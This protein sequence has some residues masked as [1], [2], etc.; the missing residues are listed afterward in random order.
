MDQ[1]LLFVLFAAT[2]ILGWWGHRTAALILF[3]LSLALSA[4]DYL[5]H[6]T[7]A[8]PLPF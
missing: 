6:A 2:M 3:F 4:A 5:H 8:L 7:D 1:M